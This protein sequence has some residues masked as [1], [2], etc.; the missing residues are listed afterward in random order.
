M[1]IHYSYSLNH[2]PQYINPIEYRYIYHKPHRQCIYIID[3]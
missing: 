2:T 1:G 3:H